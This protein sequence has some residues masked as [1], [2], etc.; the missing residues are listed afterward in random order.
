MVGDE[1]GAIWRK[2]DT[3]LAL[4]ERDEVDAALR[5][6]PLVPETAT[7]LFWRKEAES[8]QGTAV[9]PMRERYGN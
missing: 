3:G 7:Q 1:M 4:R 5:S 8:V 9:V 6:T 2:T